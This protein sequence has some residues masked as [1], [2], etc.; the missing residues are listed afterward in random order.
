MQLKPKKEY[1]VS[2]DFNGSRDFK[3]YGTLLVTRSKFVRMQV[4][5]SENYELNTEKRFEVG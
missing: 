5:G 1:Y 2:Q 4:R 3:V